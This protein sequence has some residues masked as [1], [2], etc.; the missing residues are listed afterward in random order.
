MYFLASCAGFLL[1][2][3]KGAR[4]GG[5]VDE[6]IQP[7]F[8]PRRGRLTFSIS[9]FVFHARKEHIKFRELVLKDVRTVSKRRIPRCSSESWSDP[10]PVQPSGETLSS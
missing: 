9:T 7:D 6:E 5:W 8:G 1:V 10:G 2:V 3:T 4:I